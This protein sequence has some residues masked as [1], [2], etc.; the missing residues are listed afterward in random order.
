MKWV[1][2]EESK[3]VA[4]QADALM[5]EA[6]GKI[7]GRDFKQAKR[8]LEK[9]VDIDPDGIRADYFLGMLNA[10]T[11]ANHAFSAQKYFAHANRREPNNIGLLNNLALSEM[12]TGKYSEALDHWAAAIR[13]S[14]TDLAPE[15]VQN[16]GRFVSEGTA[17]KLRGVSTSHVKPP[18]ACTGELRP[19]KRTEA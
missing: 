1:T 6:F 7:Q 11:L 10:P 13:L 5:E 14:Q 4:R 12:K 15:V 3:A 9:A 18:A 16:V 2:V 8:L 19:R 17:K